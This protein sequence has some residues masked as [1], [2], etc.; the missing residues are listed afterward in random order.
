[1]L[2]ILG[3][4]WSAHVKI[5]FLSKQERDAFGQHK[6]RFILCSRWHGTG[7]DNT[8]ELH[9]CLPMNGWGLDNTSEIQFLSS[10]EWE[11]LVNRT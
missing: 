4:V 1:M 5:H 9:V 8:A 11:G 2:A 7:V 6:S 3:V 10:H